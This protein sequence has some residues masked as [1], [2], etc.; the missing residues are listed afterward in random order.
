MW[1]STVS[2]ILWKD[3]ENELGLM[4]IY[5][6]IIIDRKPRYKS[7]GKFISEAFWDK[8]REMVKNAHPMADNW[9]IELSQRQPVHV[10]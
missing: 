6:R 4:P 9:N 10:L 8:A 7:S 1:K 3:G 2:L 5:L